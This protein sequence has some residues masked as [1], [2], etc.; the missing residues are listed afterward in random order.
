MDLE[1]KKEKERRKEERKEEEKGGRQKESRQEVFE[2]KALHSWWL[3][4]EVGVGKDSVF[5]KGL[6]TGNVAMLQ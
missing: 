4:A 5:F 1:R 6:P 3:L 2:A